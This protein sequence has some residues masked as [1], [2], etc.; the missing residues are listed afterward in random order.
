MSSVTQPVS[1]FRRHAWPIASLLLAVTAIVDSRSGY[2]LSLLAFYFVPVALLSWHQG[3]RDGL[4][5]SLIAAIT[6]FACDSFNGHTYDYEAIRYWNALMRLI[7]FSIGGYSYASLHKAL[8]DREKVI[9]ELRTTLDQVK[10]LSGYLPTCPCCQRIRLDS[11]DWQGLESYVREQSRIEFISVICPHCGEEHVPK[12]E[13][14][15][16]IS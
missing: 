7:V 14:P 10:T 5:M 8:K 16:S 9:S 13:P 6:W 2:Q 1:F 15:A 12:G 4:L 11:G 3:V